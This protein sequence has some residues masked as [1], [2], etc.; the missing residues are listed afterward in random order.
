MI[1]NSLYG[2]KC[3]VSKEHV[4]S[5]SCHFERQ[6]LILILSMTPPTRQVT[7]NISTE[8]ETIVKESLSGSIWLMRSTEPACVI[9]PSE[10]RRNVTTLL[11]IGSLVFLR[12]ARMLYPLAV[13]SWYTPA[14][15]SRNCKGTGLYNLAWSRATRC[16]APCFRIVAKKRWQ[17]ISTFILSCPTTP[18]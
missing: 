12:S 18:N 16:I 8:S 7:T 3:R 13:P 6:L 10:K 15:T 5:L 11:R 1:V 4:W 2:S 9:E 17:G 14:T